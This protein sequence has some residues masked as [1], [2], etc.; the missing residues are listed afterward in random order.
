MKLVMLSL[1][2]MLGNLYTN[3]KHFSS[4]LRIEY[5]L[6]IC[7]NTVVGSLHFSSMF[8]AILDAAFLLSLQIHK[9]YFHIIPPYI[10]KYSTYTNF[11][12]FS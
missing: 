1:K 9:H 4:E 3:L 11:S 7:L 6:Y 2:P 8:L 5:Y 12:H 10:E